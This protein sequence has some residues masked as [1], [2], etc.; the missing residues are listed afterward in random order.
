VS[1]ER[2]CIKAVGDICLDGVAADPF[3]GVAAELDADVLFGNLEC[4]FA[5]RGTPADKVVFN[6]DPTS[7]RFLVDHGFDVLC[8]ANNHVMDFG[9]EGLEDTLAVLERHGLVYNGAGRSAKEASA[10]TWVEAKGLRVAVLSTADA[11][12]GDADRPGVSAINTKAMAATIRA[13]RASADVVVASY[14]GGIELDT[15]PSPSIVR[16]L[17]SL[18]DAGAD[19]VLGHHPHV[20]QAA[21]VYRG[22][23][24][25]YSLGNFVFDNRRYGQRAALAAMTAILEVDVDLDPATRRVASVSYRYV[26]AEIGP[27]FSPRKIEGEERFAAHV[28]DLEAQLARVD[29]GAVDIQRL[30]NMTGAIRH[31]SLGT[32]VRY[33]VRHAR[34]FTFKE[35]VVGAGLVLRGVMRRRPRDGGGE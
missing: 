7:A 13:V 15:T 32:L 6:A 27:D 29:G 3:V 2:L 26:P 25:A 23:V 12:G 10:P 21:E 31:K 9:V 24:I 17:R 16:N 11:T 5:E 35:L 22:R 8:L 30:Q 34:D 18:V 19:V 33:G 1:E 28:A 4:C 14:H 20:L